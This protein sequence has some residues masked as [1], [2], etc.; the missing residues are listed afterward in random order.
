M[1]A[2]SVM[3][4]RENAQPHQL[5]PDEWRTLLID[6]GRCSGR[7]WAATHIF[8]EQVVR[9]PGSSWA[10]IGPTFKDAT[11]LVANHLMATLGTDPA[12]FI[13][14]WDHDKGILHLLAGGRIY[15]DGGNDGAWRIQGRDLAGAL[16]DNL[17]FYD[18]WATTWDESLRYAV[19]VSPAR[20]V[21]TCLPT[22]QGPAKELVERLLTDETV[23]KLGVNHTEDS[24]K[25]TENG[26]G[27][28]GISATGPDRAA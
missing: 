18:K 7:T 20:I 24:G 21:A 15:C 10:V 14:S 6:G 13:K 12:W 11:S 9:H 27:V 22:P 25:P 28:D 23:T 26:P 17:D 1:T 3:T 16:V 5:P 2:P 19:R 8:A 4:W